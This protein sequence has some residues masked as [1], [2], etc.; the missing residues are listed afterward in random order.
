M[1]DLREPLQVE[2]CTAEAGRNLAVAETVCTFD[3]IRH[4]TNAKNPAGVAIA[5]RLLA[6]RT[7]AT[8]HLSAR[9]RSMTSDDAG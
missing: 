3:A 2:G 5:H 7:T 8:A 9:T 4:G 1:I 6:H